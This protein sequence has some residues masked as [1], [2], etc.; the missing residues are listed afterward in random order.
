MRPEELPAYLQRLQT[1]L[2][3]EG[4]KK[5]AYAMAREYHSVLTD[6]TLVQ[7]SH[8]RGTPTSAAPGEPPALVSGA[9]RRSARLFPAVSSGAYKAKSRVAPL[10]KYARIQEM[11]G[12][13]QALHTYVDR[14]GRV[15]QGFLRWGSGDSVH[16]AKR[17]RIPPR[18]YMRPTHRKTVEDGRLRNA[19]I[20]AL[21]GLIP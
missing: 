8:P 5:V 1:K 16:F 3:E 7:S 4:P 10:I 19:A 11:G 2:A 12:V 21:R 9:L 18:P 14:H 17:V 13:V 6:E 15:Q 20:K